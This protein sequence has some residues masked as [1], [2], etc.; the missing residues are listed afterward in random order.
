MKCIVC[1]NTIRVS[2]SKPSNPWFQFD[3]E[4]STSYVAKWNRK[5]PINVEYILV[6][7]DTNYFVLDVRDD[8]YRSRILGPD[9]HVMQSAPGRDLFNTCITNM[10]AYL[11]PIKPE[12]K[13]L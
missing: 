8:Q 13:L 6:R 5:G 7:T 2:R 12:W 11:A 3:C 9:L 4:C 10:A 1:N